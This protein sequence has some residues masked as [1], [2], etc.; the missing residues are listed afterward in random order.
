MGT[1]TRGRAA[2][3][4]AWTGSVALDVAD[5][6]IAGLALCAATLALP[7]VPFYP[8]ITCP[9]RAAT[10]IPCPLCGLTTSVR[11]TLRLD[12]AEAL[13]LNPGGLAMVG[14]A[15]ALLVTGRPRLTV[16]AVA[17]PILIA[18]LWVFELFRF[19]RL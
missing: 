6:R 4:R 2:S 7:I 17:V 10:G 19:D 18:C 5:L 16:P 9:L 8:G 3:L 12:V 14:A 13:A 15:V 11:A 1:S